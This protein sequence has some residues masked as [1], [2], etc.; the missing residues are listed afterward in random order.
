MHARCVN[1]HVAV[2][3]RDGIFEEP[4]FAG[5]VGAISYRDRL[6]GFGVWLAGAHLDKLSI[7]AR[8]VNLDLDF[9]SS[10][11]RNSTAARVAPGAAASAARNRSIS[12]LF[13]IGGGQ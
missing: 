11:R 3:G 6:E 10:S 7:E 12:A 13:L 9:L 4:A 2:V 8:P 5:A 1:R